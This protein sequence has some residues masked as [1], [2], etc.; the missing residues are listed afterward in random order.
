MLKKVKITK[1]ANERIVERIADLPSKQR[2]ELVEAAKERGKNI[3]QLYDTNKKAW[4]YLAR[5]HAAA[6]I[7]LYEDKVFV[8][9]KELNT[10]ITIYK[11]QNNLLA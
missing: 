3:V 4:D 2:Q 9:N 1:H 11:L 6:N 7:R 10:L 8:F 5:K